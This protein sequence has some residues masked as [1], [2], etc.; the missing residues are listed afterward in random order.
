[1]RSFNVLPNRDDRITPRDASTCDRCAL[2]QFPPAPHPNLS[3]PH[4][5]ARP[6]STRT[7]SS[8]LS[9]SNLKEQTMRPQTIPRSTTVTLSFFISRPLSQSSSLSHF[10]GR[11]WV[12]RGRLVQVCPAGKAFPRPSHYHRS[13][14]FRILHNRRLLP[15]PLQPCVSFHPTQLLRSSH[16]L[17]KHPRPHHPYNRPC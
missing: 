17:P 11:L 8:P 13:P 7:T 4:L 15:Q 6:C 16:N 10:L 12:S 3:P 2:Y 5:S 9:T 1:M 14:K